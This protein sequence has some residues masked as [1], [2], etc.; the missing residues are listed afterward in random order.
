MRVRAVWK[1]RSE[2]DLDDVDNRW[3][4]WDTVIE[5]WEPTGEPDMDPRP[6]QQY[7]F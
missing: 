2:R 1:P 6:L 3:G 5:R 7:A 4:A